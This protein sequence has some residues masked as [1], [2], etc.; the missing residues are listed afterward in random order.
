MKIALWGAFAA[1]TTLGAFAM[2]ANP[3]W[4]P[5]DPPRE[6][7]GVWIATVCNIDWPSKPGLAADAQRRELVR[8]FDLAQKLRLNAVVLQV[9]PACDTF[10][11]SALEP[12]S[13]YL[14]GTQ[15]KTPGYDPLAFAVEEAHRRG[16]ELHAWFNP[17]RAWHPTGKSRPSDLHLSRSQ[18]GMVRKYGNLM[19]L[20][21]GDPKAQAHTLQVILDVVRRYDIDGVHI[22]DYF[23]PYPE[24]GKVF[25]D[26][27][28]FLAYRS[29]GGRLG[30]SGWRRDNVDGFV[31]RLYEGIK[32][33][34]RWVKFGISPFGIYRPNVPSGIEAGI[35]QYE[36][37]HADAK[38]WLNEGWCDYFAPQLYWAIAQNKQSYPKLLDW[39]I[40]E[41]TQGRHLWPG[42]YASRVIPGV[43]TWQP[44]EIVDQV[45][46]TRRTDG[47]GGN[48]LYSMQAIAKDARGLSKAL[49][50]AY[51][52]DALIPAS[53]WLDETPPAL[54]SAR[55]SGSAI[56]WTP[57][58][59][60]A[61]RWWVSAHR[62]RGQTVWHLRVHPAGV[63]RFE[64]AMAGKTL[65]A[66]AVAA[67]DR[68]GNRSDWALVRP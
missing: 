36:D 45:Q 40:S 4:T 26:D 3:L 49:E 37:L 19:W 25:P 64:T 1:M 58:A 48:V 17:F 11:E 12:W 56:E 8:L 13:E 31:K 30:R 7:R 43:G 67:V 38:K 21:P 65:E 57:G 41:N 63:R 29:G 54:P 60:E 47:A 28:T 9:R 55:V 32:A 33:E 23:Y 51:V 39:W 59:G 44:K 68:C 52:K 42:N 66:A 27:P 15:G 35:D 22:D 10:Y 62:Y 46:L 61:A 18:P 16:L 50:S 34:K 6:F 24:K 20:D 2:P 5:P 14:T 53:P